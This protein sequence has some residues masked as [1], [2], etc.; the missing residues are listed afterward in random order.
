MFERSL[1]L[2]DELVKLS[3]ANTV[4]RAHQATVCTWMAELSS[5]KDDSASVE[6][7]RAR[8]AEILQS[9]PGK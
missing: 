3:P 8:S 2:I 9:I 7:W 6:T 5:A 4:W 1:E